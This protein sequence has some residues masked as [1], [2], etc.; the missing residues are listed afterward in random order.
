MQNNPEPGD[1]KEPHNPD[2]KDVEPGSDADETPVPEGSG[3]PPNPNQQS[4]EDNG[5]EQ[6]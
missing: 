6:S 1:E 5:D 3:L 4:K 2:L